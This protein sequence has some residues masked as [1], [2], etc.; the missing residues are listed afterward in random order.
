ML[1]G[2]LNSNTAIDYV[3]KYE[4]CSFQSVSLVRVKDGLF[5]L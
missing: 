1:C 4:V 5:H 3:L 2:A